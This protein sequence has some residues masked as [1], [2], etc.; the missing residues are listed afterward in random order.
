LQRE[1]QQNTSNI[2]CSLRCSIF[3]VVVLVVAGT[4]RLEE[5]AHTIKGTFR[6]SCSPA[7]ARLGIA[8]PPVHLLFHHTGREAPLADTRSDRLIT[9]RC[10]QETPPASCGKE[11]D[12]SPGIAVVVVAAQ[13][14]T[15]IHQETHDLPSIASEQTTTRDRGL[16]PPIHTSHIAYCWASDV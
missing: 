11:T 16:H 10:E 2:H 5:G 13:A 6:P 8:K 9:S 1:T 12:V 4:G 3:I 7:R 14:G 15:S